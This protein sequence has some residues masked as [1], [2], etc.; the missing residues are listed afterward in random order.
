[1]N[2]FK[3]SILHNT[4]KRASHLLPPPLLQ[5]ARNKGL[6]PKRKKEQRNPRVKHRKK[7]DRAK[8]R[9]KGQVR[10]VVADEVIYGGERSGIKSTVSRSIKLN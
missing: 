9:R 6:T 2:H 7:F 1:M 4:A 10:S 5:I 8:V 3:E